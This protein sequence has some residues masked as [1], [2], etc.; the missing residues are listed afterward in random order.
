MISEGGVNIENFRVGGTN[1]SL[2]D[3]CADIARAIRYLELS[4]SAP[5]SARNATH[6]FTANR[7]GWDSHDNQGGSIPGNIQALAT[8]I[9]GLVYYLNEWG[10]LD[11]TIIF[12]YGEFGRTNAQNGSSGTDHAEAGH[13][14]VL[15]GGNRINS[16]VFGPEASASQATSQNFFTAQVPQTGILRSILAKAF[17]DPS[18]LNSVFSHA[19]P[20]TVPQ[21]WLL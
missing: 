1:N 21:G 9:N 17:N 14:L 16:G 11:S 12:A 7:G 3:S 5:A 2:A 6:I 4:S 19:M 15:G 18:G 10:L 8:A 13:F 20:G